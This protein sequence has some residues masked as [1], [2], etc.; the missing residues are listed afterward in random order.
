[1][2]ALHHQP[3][4]GDSLPRSAHELAHRLATIAGQIRAMLIYECDNGSPDVPGPPPGITSHEE[5]DMYAQTLVYGLF[6]E[7]IT[8]NSPP[9]ERYMPPLP[10]RLI[11]LR[12]ECTALLAHP[13][14]TT[15]LRA[16]NGP[17]AS[18]EH[19]TDDVVT[20]F[21]ETFLAAYNPTLRERRGVYFTPTPVVSYIVQSVDHLLRAHFD[22]AAGLADEQSIIVDPAMG[23]ATFLHAVVQRIY[24]THT[25]QGTAATWHTNAPRS[26]MPR[27]FGFEV[28]LAPYLIAHLKLGLL[29][30]ETGCPLQRH[31]LLHLY[32]YSGLDGAPGE[33]PLPFTQLLA[34]GTQQQGLA[35]VPII[36]G[37]P[38]YAR[39]SANQGAWEQQIRAAC[40]PR[41]H[42]REQNPKLLLDDYVRFL[43]AGQWHIEQ[44]GCG[45]LALITNHSYLESPTFRAMRRLL[46]QTFT[47]IYLLNLHGNRKKK[48]TTPE[49]TLDENVFDIQQ[50]VAIGL[51]VKTPPRM[52][53]QQNSPHLCSADLWGSRASK[54][55]WLKTH[56]VAST[57]W[58]NLT[59]S[60][61]FFL[62]VPHRAGG[63]NNH[64]H[65]GGQN[66]RIAD[67]FPLH[68][69]GIKTHRD[70]LVFAFDRATLAARLDD[71]S[72]PT[73]QD[74]LLREYY[75]LSDS[76][77]WSLARQRRAL[78][79]STEWTHTL[80]R[81]LYR[82]FDHRILAYHP[83]LI[84]RP[85]TEVMQHM[86]AGS[87]LG[88]ITVRQVAE[89]TMSHVFVADCLVEGRVLLSNRGTGYI[90][91]L[92]LFE[93]NVARTERRPN[94]APAFVAALEHR[95][96]L[97]FIPDGP[98][99]LARTF[100]PEDVLHYLYAVLHCPA[101][102]RAYIESLR[103]DFPRIPLPRGST[104][105]AALVAKGA[106]L[107][108][109]HL[110]RL[111]GSSNG[112]GG[113]G[114][115]PL[116]IDPDAQGVRFSGEGTNL[117]QSVQY[118]A[119]NKQQP[120]HVMINA[121]RCI[122][123]VEPEIWQMQVGG[124]HPLRK[125][126]KQRLGHTL[127]HADVLHALRVIVALRETRR[128]MGEIEHICS[129]T[130]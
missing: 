9:F 36:L 89:S 123:G 55:A 53:K 58:D 127:S 117:V 34:G 78:G 40:Y 2:A 121:A 64:S 62:F 104:T 46:M 75:K 122:E 6:A 7:R 81:C 24:A 57:P 30:A 42:I 115:A 95:L 99:N 21:Y 68:S 1:M 92:Y 94:L 91:P 26:V 33:T 107:V 120:G 60:P 29:F 116:L 44:A 90:F 48:E 77:T 38:P 113:S 79:K 76:A 106:A 119:P 114:G 35:T 80:T 61:P 88:L 50:G 71:L 112:I 32:R 130:Q 105:F 25:E 16:K 45:I 70:H 31:D 65:S 74:E 83:A 100:G 18:D 69:T 97:T 108:D 118:V 66:W 52:N 86:L 43:Y 125:W 13:E 102:R 11:P 110:L 93:G 59:P 63:W 19:Q 51:F 109:L 128:I 67:I 3:A 72:T 8:G 82:P 10:P 27:L 96:R 37:N 126:L 129:V 98:G 124:Y 14:I 15:L 73:L 20:H 101:E 28:L 23:T 56:D 49:G 5:A 111:P 84:D 41:D 87:N 47:H 54:Y 12:D 4:P 17:P 39:T 22:M 85:R 103:V